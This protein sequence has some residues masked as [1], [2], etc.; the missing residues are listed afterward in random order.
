MIANRTHIIQLDG[1][2]FYA[3]LM[4]MIA[5]WLQWHWQSD[6]LLSLPFTNGVILFFVLSGFLISRILLENRKKYVENK[7][8]LQKLYLNFYIRRILRIVPLYYAVVIG[9]T[10][11]DYK[12]SVELFPWLV[13]Y[14][15]NIHQALHNTF[16]GDF[17]HFWSLSVEEQFYIF[18][19]FLILLKGSFRR[20]K[21]FVILILISL[22]SR[23]CFYAFSAHWMWISY[24][25]LNCLYSFGIGALL[26]Y[27]IVERKA[28]VA[29]LTNKWMLPL[30]TAVYILFFLIQYKLHFD[31]YKHIF[32]EFMFAS[33]AAL[34]IL[35]AF[36]NGFTGVF[37]FLLENKFVVYSGIISY[38]LYVYHLFIPQLGY[39]VLTF[40]GIHIEN[41]YLLFSIYYS[42]TL[43]V[44]TMSWYA[45]EKP[46]NNFKIR[47]PYYSDK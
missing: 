11:L 15:L 20:S 42:L 1:L 27:W 34:I 5:H 41:A 43:I 18:W 14:T 3:V 8:Q 9:L 30:A 44:A 16:V 47:F 36:N 35:K 31:W 6:F 19:P 39:Y 2:R 37:K 28:I 7:K 24:F 13:T 4:V 46:I 22:I 17:S 26:A 45:F 12:N 29:L 32:E 40:L 38:G 10:I 23:I 21:L 33:L 25:T